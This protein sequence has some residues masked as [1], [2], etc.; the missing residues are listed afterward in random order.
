ML[1]C[2]YGLTTNQSTVSIVQTNDERKKMHDEAFVQV[3]RRRRDSYFIQL[4]LLIANRTRRHTHARA[5]Q[6]IVSCSDNMAWS[7][8]TRKILAHSVG[9]FCILVFFSL[10]NYTVY[11][12]YTTIATSVLQRQEYKKFLFHIVFGNWLAINIYFNYIMAWLSSPGHA[13]DYQR[14][15]MQYAQCRK[16]STNK[17]PRTHHCSWCDLCI[18]KFDHHCPC[19]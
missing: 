4:G 16:C 19:T 9:Y 5:Q 2:N 6:P 11:V 7:V 8:R 14:L 13:K 18:L 17:P 10:T 15:A 3:C 12:Y 1:D